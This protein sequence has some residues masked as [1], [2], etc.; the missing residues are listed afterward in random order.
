MK[1]FSLVITF[2]LVASLWVPLTASAADGCSAAGPACTVNGNSGACAQ[3]P[4]TGDFYCRPS[5]LG[6]PG[7]GS[8]GSQSSGFVA[9]AP[10]PG[11]TDA[12]NTSVVN[13]SSLANFF[14]NL[15]KYL[16]G[17]AAVIAIIQIT[18]SGI[19]IAT[20]QDSVATV[21]DSKGNIYN[22]II[23][24]VLVLA[25]VLVF[26][27]INPSILN[28]SLKL[29]EIKTP[30]SNATGSGGGNNGGGSVVDTATGCTVTGTLLKKAACSTRQKAQDFAAS[31]STGSGS[32]SSCQME[33]SSG[34]VDTV[35]YATCSTSSGSVTGPFVFLDTSHNLNPLQIFSNY[36]PLAI[37][38][39]N[40][41]NGA[42]AVRFASTCTQDGGVTCVS[43]DGVSSGI[44]SATCTY[45]T[46]QSSSQSNKCYTVTLSCR[47][48]SWTTNLNVGSSWLY[49]CNGSPSWT[50]I[51]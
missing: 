36:I 11:L 16:I 2:V 51:R 8:S 38:A 44:V 43:G 23:G 30:G 6:A 31:C 12:A 37:S 49:V 40:P 5:V 33:N 15:Y 24:L 42:D 45:T 46:G 27:I 28:L 1:K 34:C 17:L 29:P 47:P 21:T 13:A 39:S 26:S 14:N 10:I 48:S 25:P 22:A 50:P 3:N 19:R 4:D 32:V 41:N 7:A 9:L 35:H 18:W 20:N